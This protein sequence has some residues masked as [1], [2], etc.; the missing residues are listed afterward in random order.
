MARVLVPMDFSK[1]AYLALNWA[2]KLVA[3]QPSS[4]LYL[5]HVRRLMQDKASETYHLEEARR[6]MRELRAT[7]PTTV[8]TIMM[9]PTGRIPDEI[10]NI[11]RQE[12]IDLV[13]M[14]TRGRFG[15]TLSLQSSFTEETIRTT[16]CPVLVLH[17]NQRT[18]AQ[19]QERFNGLFPEPADIPPL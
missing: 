1:E 16:P 12:P 18:A 3:Q 8:A 11:C 17:L 14:T 19:L 2:L 7:I 6:K 5:V 10:A 9:L 4:T 13:V 15:Q